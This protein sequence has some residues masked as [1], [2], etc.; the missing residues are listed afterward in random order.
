[1]SNEDIAI[2]TQRSLL[3]S[4]RPQE[5]LFKVAVL[6]LNLLNAENL[7]PP[8]FEGAR[9]ADE[10]VVMS[11]DGEELY[12]SMKL[13]KKINEREE[14][15]VGFFDFATNPIYGGILLAV[16][17]G[18]GTIRAAALQA[19]TSEIGE[20]EPNGTTELISYGYPKIGFRTSEAGLLIDAFSR[21]EVLEDNARPSFDALGYLEVRRIRDVIS[22]VEF[23]KRKERFDKEVIFWDSII[24]I[25]RDDIDWNCVSVDWFN[26]IAGM[27]LRRDK[28]E[29][30]G[31]VQSLS[32]RQDIDLSPQIAGEWCFPAC[33]EMLLGYYRF[34]YRQEVLAFSLGLG[35]LERARPL[36]RSTEHDVVRTIERLT[37]GILKGKM[38][39]A[40]EWQD[41]RDEVLATRPVIGLIDGHCRLVVGASLLEVHMNTEVGID[42]SLRGLSLHDPWPAR[43]GS[44]I[45]WE[46]FDAITYVAMFGGELESLSDEEVGLIDGLRL[47]AETYLARSVEVWNL[48]RRAK[49][50]IVERVS[51]SV[52]GLGGWVVGV[53]EGG[54]LVG[55][56]QFD[57]NLSF[58][59]FREPEDDFL[60]T[61][62][63]SRVLSRQFAREQVR[64]SANPGERVTEPELVFDDESTLVWKAEGKNSGLGRREIK[65]EGVRLGVQQVD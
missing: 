20:D 54:Q 19:V 8:D 50:G 60:N 30:Y 6:E 13:L 56:M 17:E 27:N 21:E 39:R 16:G 14:E 45:Y 36:P 46:N 7:L 33:V 3:G 15:L 24:S 57:Q 55:V 34:H 48:T 22:L 9:I 4:R 43:K 40:P 23:I 32:P 65:L 5:S 44:R 59:G 1:M 26:K 35:D 61:R 42:L 47:K 18:Y 58:S 49:I 64:R 2:L 62:L 41:F 10:V 31:V 28:P 63:T 51:D 12:R 25:S 52:R 53:E 37:R 11:S 29:F 38:T